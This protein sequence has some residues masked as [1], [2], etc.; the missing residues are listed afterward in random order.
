M[1]L[2]SLRFSLM[3]RLYSRYL[4]EPSP[5]EESYPLSVSPVIV[6][7]IM[8]DE[9][10][11]DPVMTDATEDLSGAGTVT[12]FTVP[13]GERW[14][15]QWIFRSATSA[16]SRVALDPSSPGADQPISPN[17]TAELRIDVRGITLVAGDSVQMDATGSGGDSAVTLY[18]SYDRERLNE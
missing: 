12:Y 16:N 2:K 10:L 6:P 13:S 18:I 3:T 1:V 4:L 7:V 17:G 14:R 5:A 8:A 9:V 11:V 15:L